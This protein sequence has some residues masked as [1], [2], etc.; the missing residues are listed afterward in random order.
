MC[1]THAACCHDCSRG[2]FDCGRYEEHGMTVVVR[3]PRTG[4]VDA[5]LRAALEHSFGH[6][7]GGAAEITEVRRRPCSFH[8][9]YR[10]EELEIALS[11]GTCIDAI[12]KD[13]SPGTRLKEARRIK[14]RFLYE[15]RREI[16]VYQHVLTRLGMGTAACHGAL[17]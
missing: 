2:W 8:S 12:W 9:S 6:R 1:S 4:G 3:R 16:S 10:L 14:P 17:I 5:A 13:L 11:D 7:V 15:P